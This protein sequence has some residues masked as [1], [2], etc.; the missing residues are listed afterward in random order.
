MLLQ[1]LIRGLITVV[2]A[3]LVASAV[4]RLRTKPQLDEYGSGRLLTTQD[5]FSRGPDAVSFNEGER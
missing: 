2:T 1:L 4:D 5:R 3:P